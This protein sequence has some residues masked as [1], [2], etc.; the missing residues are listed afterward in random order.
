VQVEIGMGR[1]VFNG[2]RW[3]WGVQVGIGL[4]SLKLVCAS[5]N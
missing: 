5:W 3:N 4:C 2:A 1:L